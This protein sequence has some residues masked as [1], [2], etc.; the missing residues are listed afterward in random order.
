MR[1]LFILTA[2]VA[3]VGGTAGTAQAQITSRP[4]DVNALVIRPVEA[5]TGLVGNTVNFVSRVT[6][7]AIDNSFLVRTV[8]NLFGGRS[9]VPTTQ[10]GLSPLP[11]PNQY[12][13]TYYQSPIQPV[14]PTY[15][16]LRR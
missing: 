16:V 15:Q 5:T 12:L 11:S 9:N 8:N 13:S 2:A 7:N 4:V 6:A 14:F 3:V 1:N 10:G